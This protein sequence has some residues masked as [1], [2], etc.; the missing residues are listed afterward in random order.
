MR[1]TDANETSSELGS[2]FGG[3]LVGMFQLRIPYAD[4]LINLAI[5]LPIVSVDLG[6]HDGWYALK[7]P[8]KVSPVSSEDV[9]LKIEFLDLGDSVYSCITI[10]LTFFL[11]ITTHSSVSL[12]QIP[13]ALSCKTCNVLSSLICSVG[14]AGIEVVAIAGTMGQSRG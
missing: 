6:Y 13:S 7:S 4:P 10:T 12:F 11:F 2:A 5:F 14:G 8:R 1:E 3:T 9:L